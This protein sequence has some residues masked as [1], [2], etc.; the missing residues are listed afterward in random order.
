MHWWLAAS[1]NHLHNRS[2]S[3]RRCGLRRDL[4]AIGPTPPEPLKGSPIMS[5]F[6]RRVP[7][8]VTCPAYCGKP[9]VIWCQDAREPT[10][11]W[12][13]GRIEGGSVSVPIATW[14]KAPSRTTDQSSEPQRLQ[15]TSCGD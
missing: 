9:S 8:Y 6:S 1:D 13:V 15:C 10:K 5:L 4:N 3:R 14:T 12:A 7:S 11:M 2:L